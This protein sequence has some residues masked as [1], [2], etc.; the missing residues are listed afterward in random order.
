MNLYHHLKTG[1]QRRMYDQQPKRNPFPLRPRHVPLWYVPR[2][3]LFLF[4][5]HFFLKDREIF[6]FLNRIGMIVMEAL[7][8][9]VPDVAWRN[10]RIHLGHHPAEEDRWERQLRRVP[11]HLWPLHGHI[12]VIIIITTITIITIINAVPAHRAASTNTS[13]E[14]IVRR[15]TK[16]PIPPISNR[17]PNFLPSSNSKGKS[18]VE[19]VTVDGTTDTGNLKIPADPVIPALCHSANVPINWEVA[20]VDLR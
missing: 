16:M 17:W 4:P 14:D 12:D 19:P 7:A 6:H 15:A 18:V 9:V 10:I 2:P 13:E 3:F 8:E 5:K 1:H 11:R 20:P